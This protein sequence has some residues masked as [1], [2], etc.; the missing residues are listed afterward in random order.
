MARV[1]ERYRDEVAPALREE[2]QR[3]NPMAIPRLEKIVVSM[4]IG[5]AIQEKK[6]L[7]AAAKDLAT[8]T[9][10]KPLICKARKSV[11]NFKL[12]TGMETGLKVTLRGARMYEFFDRLV[13]VAIPRVRDFR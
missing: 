1:A 6:R 9:G 4:G 5:L 13:N 10:Q 11:S 12:R 3:T 7:E 8:I 2:L